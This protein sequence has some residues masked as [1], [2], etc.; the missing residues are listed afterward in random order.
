MTTGWA[1]P[2][3]SRTSI[4]RVAPEVKKTGWSRL[5]TNL[6]SSFCFSKIITSTAC[7]TGNKQKYLHPISLQESGKGI[8]KWLDRSD[9]HERHVDK[10]D[11]ETVGL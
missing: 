10:Y 9:I 5:A 6:C 8:G 2:T 3:V 7:F 11:I 4:D 1:T